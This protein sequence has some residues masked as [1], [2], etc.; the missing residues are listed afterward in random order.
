MDTA[1]FSS[2]KVVFAY[3]I[4]SLIWILFSDLTVEKIFTNIE[5]YTLAQSIKGGVFVVVTSLMLWG[6]I[7]KNLR[8]LRAADDLDRVTG[9]NSPSVF[10]RNLD[11][12]LNHATSNKKKIL[13]ILDIDNFNSASASLGFDDTNNFLKDIADIIDSASST[14]HFS[15][16]IH[17]D[18]F[19]SFTKLDQEISTDKYLSYIQQQVN[20]CAHRYG[21]E[22]TCCI[23]V[24]IYPADGENAKKL[25]QS[26][27]NALS[28]AK[29]TKNSIQY[30]DKVLTAQERN[31]KAMVQELHKAI[32]NNQIEVVF[33]PKYHLASMELSGVEVLAR[34]THE[35]F[36][37]V[38]PATFIALAE[39]NNLCAA[40]TKLVIAK[41]SQQLTQQRMMETKIKKVSI[42][43]SA[44]EFNCATH[45][46]TLENVLQNNR[47]I[48]P[49]LCLE[50]TETAAL[51]DIDN[52]ADI[53][54]KFKQYGTTFS[55]DDFGV[56]YTS[57]EIFKKLV[58]NEIKIDRSFIMNVD[59]DERSAIIVK[60]I[61]DI[62]RGFGIDVV[63][64][65]VET[66]EQLALLKQMNCHQA[67]GYYL[68]RPM[69]IDQ[70]VT[71]L[72]A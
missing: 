63:A 47:H 9:L 17:V 1:K 67:Q 2:F 6:L 60:G 66:P 70:L 19:A 61:I 65:G 10:Y 4:F 28:E 24:A 42:N 18:A 33:Q 64:E 12:K 41:S 46:K 5:H 21:I 23:G 3:L 54:S 30:H 22:T 32:E 31:R 48:S 57:F 58:V 53:I 26:A 27:K 62:A 13:Y 44:T 40:I 29:K 8:D 15:S 69:A 45:M 59:T 14:K 50:I 43:I 11:V 52:C 55:I 37:V 39:E 56:G 51:N 20:Q 34:W 38:P 25:I 72:G 16:R 35:T 49:Y 68:G 7:Y 36:G 71:H